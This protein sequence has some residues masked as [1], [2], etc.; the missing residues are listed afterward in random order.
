MLKLFDCEK[1]GKPRIFLLFYLFS[2]C[3]L[4]LLLCTPEN[5]LEKYAFIPTQVELINF[6]KWCRNSDFPH[7]P[8]GKLIEYPHE[9]TMRTADLKTSNI[10]WNSVLSTP[11]AKYMYVDIKNMYLATPL[12]QPE[13]IRIHRKNIPKEFIDKEN[14]HDKFIND[15]IHLRIIRG[16]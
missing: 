10:L 2:L 6:E 7:L 12:D 16:M 8:G 13:Y 15:F 9:L 3:P 14:L 4:F 5:T 11:N 1:S